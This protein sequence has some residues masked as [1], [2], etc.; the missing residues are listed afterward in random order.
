[1]TLEKKVLDMQSNSL[2]YLAVYMIT[3]NHGAFIE[4]AIESIMNQN[5]NFDYKLFIGEDFSSDNTR[6]IC[7]RLKNKYPDKIDLFLNSKNL[8][9]NLN[10]KQI[11]KACF[12]SGAKYIALCEGD[13][14]WTDPFKLQ[15]QVDILESN[16][17]L[18]GCFHNSEER[19][20]NDYSKASS[21]FLSF[22]G[23]REV[24]I[25]ELTQ[26]NM[27][28]T[29]SIVFKMPVS[30]ELF[31]EEFLNLPIGDWP[32]HLLNTRNGNYYY[33]PQVMS[34]RN[35]NPKSIWG[36]QNHQTNVAQV[37]LTYN[38]LIDSGWFGKEIIDLLK[39]GC[40]NLENS[41]KPQKK[42]EVLS[43]KD[44]IKNKIIRGLNK[45]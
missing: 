41:I 1:M 14:Y 40:E 26:Y 4:E 37:V 3:Y 2:P 15:K 10:A 23:G 31:S 33:L 9:A 7:I 36:M 28:P 16:P 8:G 25:Q 45:L 18:V 11:F 5:T 17:D 20:W 44:R 42:A 38:K 27:V 32:L 22:S 6:S 35:L 13:D 30:D 12:E 43:L 34:V 19:Y 24:S 39:I 29:A 21:L